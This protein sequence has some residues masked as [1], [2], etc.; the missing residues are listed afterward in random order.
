[1]QAD[2]L[3]DG[4]CFMDLGAVVVLVMPAIPEI[5]NFEFGSIIFFDFGN[6]DFAVL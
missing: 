1:M 4:K 6:T 5:S 3:V 2:R